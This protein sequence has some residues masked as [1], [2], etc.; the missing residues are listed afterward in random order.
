M[1]RDDRAR[2]TAMLHAHA[3]DRFARI[4]NDAEH[5][6]TLT[7]FG[8]VALWLGD[9]DAAAC[10]HTLLFPHSGLWV[11]DGIAARTWG[12]VDLEL[13]RLEAVLGRT[14]EAVAHLRSARGSLSAAGAR[15]L[16]GEADELAARLGAPDEGQPGEE[17]GDEPVGSCQWRRE[18][19][20]WTLRYDG[21]T[22]LMKHAKGLDDLAHLLAQPGREVPVAELYGAPGI[23]AAPRASDLGEVLDATARAAYRQRLVDLEEEVADAEAMRDLAR[24]ER[25]AAERDFLAAEL[26]AAL[27]LGGRARVAG[28]PSER[29]RKAVTNRVRLAIDRIGNV[30]ATL[31]RHLRNSVRTGIFC[32]Y[33]PEH[34][35]PWELDVTP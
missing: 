30:H 32:A 18:G 22:V 16:E 23:A 10:L 6:A 25:A 5:L 24:A 15:L 28:D 1:R 17:A 31:G 14:A 4:G 11:V 13:A 3:V 29:A 27:G 8:R 2:A 33:E 34:P 20:L 9:L 7:M 12:P 21:R 26:A 19:E 35:V